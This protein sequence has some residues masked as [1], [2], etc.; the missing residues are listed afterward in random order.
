MYIYCINFSCIHYR[1]KE[2]QVGYDIEKFKIKQE[3]KNYYIRENGNED[4]N[5]YEINT[6]KSFNTAKEYDYEDE[7][8]NRATFFVFNEREIF[9][10]I[11]LLEE[12]VD[13]AQNIIIEHITKKFEEN[14]NRIEKMT[15]A[16]KN[17]SNWIKH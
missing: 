12:D 4:Q 2:Q 7:V 11:P 10:K 5:Y 15:S 3:K 1:D 6:Y 8:L 13:N 9:G 14:L 16:F 17:K